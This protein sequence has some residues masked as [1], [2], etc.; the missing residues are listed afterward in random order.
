ML[1]KTFAAVG[2]AGLLVLGGSAAAN[3]DTYPPIGEEDVTISVSALT[4]APG[5]VSTITVEGLAE[6]TTE[7]VFVAEGETATLASA[8]PIAGAFITKPVMDGMASADFSATAAG[9]YTVAVSSL[10]AVYGSVDI[11]V[12]PALAGGPGDPGTPGGPGGLPVT[13][14]AF[15]ATALWLGLGAVGI[16]GIAVAAGVARRR[17]TSH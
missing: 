7:V 16:G 5:A 14:G 4:I 3:A 13:G 6:T 9:T 17:A 10:D 1:K 8:A 2:L 11:T 15:P 12:D